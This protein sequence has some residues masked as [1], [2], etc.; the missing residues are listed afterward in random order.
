MVTRISR[1]FVAAIILLHFS[2]CSYDFVIPSLTI[3]I[4]PSH[5]PGNIPFTYSFVSE[6]DSQH[7]RIRLWSS[8]GGDLW[9]SPA[10]LVSPE[11]KEFDLFDEVKLPSEGVIVL[12][13]IYTGTYTLE[14]EILSA[15]G[16]GHEELEF[17][18]RRLSFRVE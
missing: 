12:H 3:S 5:Q 8:T 16:L 9:N 18:T 15:R 13:N 6:R 17:L 4:E 10:T 11:V 14:F 7:C 1:L 2:S